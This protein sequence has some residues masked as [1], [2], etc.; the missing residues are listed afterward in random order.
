MKRDMDLIRLLL[1][2][3]EARGGG[4]TSQ[5][6]DLRIEGYTPEQVGHHVWLLEDGGFI[7]CVEGEVVDEAELY[8]RCL[9]WKGH[10]VLDAV[11]DPEVWRQSTGLAKRGRNESLRTVWKIAQ[12]LSESRTERLAALN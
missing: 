10:E 5:I 8:P 2:E 12:K 4:V 9:T 3:I 11:R 1:L 6:N 7:I